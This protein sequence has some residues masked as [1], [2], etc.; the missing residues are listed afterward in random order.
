MPNSANNTATPKIQE[1]SPRRLIKEVKSVRKDA[2][3]YFNQ[4]TEIEP[5]TFR[6]GCMAQAL[7]SLSF[8]EDLTKELSEAIYGIA[9]TMIDHHGKI[10]KVMSGEVT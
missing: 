2:D 1:D 8:D 3:Y 9:V 6:M 7:M 5:H 4:I 10:K